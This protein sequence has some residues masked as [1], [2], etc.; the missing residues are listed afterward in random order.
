[1]GDLGAECSVVHQ[2]NVEVLDT[3]NYELF[4]IVWEVELSFSI[5]AVT[6][7]GHRSVSFKSPPD[8]VVDT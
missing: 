1:M 6:N 4:E 5:R 2:Q 7:F 8:S 3:P